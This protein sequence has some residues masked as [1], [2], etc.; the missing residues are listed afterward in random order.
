MPS[1]Y[2]QYGIPVHNS[3]HNTVFS[4]IIQYIFIVCISRFCLAVTLFLNATHPHVSSSTYVCISRFCLAVTLFL[5]LLPK[6]SSTCYS[7][8]GGGGG[9]RG[10]GIK[11]EGGD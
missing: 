6:V 10:R 9:L 5:K 8:R 11:G 2:T 3:T 4:H 7:P 1:S